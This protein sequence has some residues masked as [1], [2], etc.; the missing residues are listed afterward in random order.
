[1]GT[2]FY[3]K[4]GMIRRAQTHLP[5]CAFSYADLFS[6]IPIFRLQHLAFKL[7]AHGYADTWS[8]FK[9]GT[10]LAHSCGSPG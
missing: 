1:M 8:L 3:I 9:G 6:G 10:Q 7:G 2:I 5:F 4:A